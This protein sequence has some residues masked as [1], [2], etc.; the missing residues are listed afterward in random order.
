MI[1]I[2][3]NAANQFVNV[4]SMPVLNSVFT[5]HNANSGPA[6][7]NAIT[8]N[9]ISTVSVFIQLLLHVPAQ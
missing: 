6:A 9:T 3:T 2:N 8:N 4:Y 5:L 7:I 1:A